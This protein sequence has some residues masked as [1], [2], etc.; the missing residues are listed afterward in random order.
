LAL[1]APIAHDLSAIA[2]GALNALW[3][4]VPADQLKTFGIINQ[5]QQVDQVGH[6]S[7]GSLQT[8]S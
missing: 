8:T 6:D 5:E 1:I 2:L 4:A 7:R 3:P